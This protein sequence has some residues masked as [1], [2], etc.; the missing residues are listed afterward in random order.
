MH[1][2]NHRSVWRCIK[3]RIV[4]VG[5]GDVYLFEGGRVCRGVHTGAMKKVSPLGFSKTIKTHKT[6]VYP[7]FYCW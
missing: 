5:G 1:S 6:Y 2:H 4:V 3:K 7:W